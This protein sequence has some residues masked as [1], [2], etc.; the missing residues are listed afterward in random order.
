MEPESPDSPGFLG[1]IRVLADGLV[2]SVQ[3]RIGLLSLEL[4]EEKYR[5]IQTFFWISAILFTGVMAITF[6]S[7]T[8]VY[9]FWENAR[10]TV[11]CS[12][13]VLYSAAMVSI[14]IAFRR[15][16]A[17]QPELLASTLQELAADRECIRA[18]S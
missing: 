17:R 3:D 15:Y 12:L 5:L 11:L 10:L 8:L 16:V 4:K 2:A 7:I 6:A 13:T 14:I 1:S 9:L 18:K